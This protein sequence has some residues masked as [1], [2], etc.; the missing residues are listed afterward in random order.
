MNIPLIDA[1]ALDAELQRISR[2]LN[3]ARFALRKAHPQDVPELKRKI[4]KLLAEWNPLF[5]QKQRLRKG[6]SGR[7]G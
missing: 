3:S 5:M 2:E 4:A 1:E 6:S 7:N